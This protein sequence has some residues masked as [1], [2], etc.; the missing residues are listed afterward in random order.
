MSNNVFS[1]TSSDLNLDSFRIENEIEAMFSIY[2]NQIE[3]YVFE[4][5]NCLKI[6]LNENINKVPI[7]HIELLVKYNKGYPRVVPELEIINRHNITTEELDALNEGIDDIAFSKS[8]ENIEMIHDICQFIQ[9]SLNDKAKKFPNNS[10]RKK[11]KE[12]ELLNEEKRIRK[13]SSAQELQKYK[14]NFNDLKKFLNDDIYCNS[15]LTKAIS[16]NFD[17]TN[18]NLQNETSGA[19]SRFI[20][21]FNII[22]KIGEGGG[23]S[24]YKVKNKFDE[25][26]YAIKRVTIIFIYG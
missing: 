18:I 11:S 6:K 1:R 17:N 5:K 22:E 20:S 3:K 19:A 7:C 13:R 8:D 4:D 15:H 10:E 16:F 24:V 23:G 26:F 14:E 25:M 12:E 21:D 2:L 9:L